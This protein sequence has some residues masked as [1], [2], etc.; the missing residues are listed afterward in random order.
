MNPTMQMQAVPAAANERRSNL[1][2]REI[3]SKL[4]EAVKAGLITRGEF[5]FLIRGRSQLMLEVATYKGMF[6]K[7]H[8]T[9]VLTR[10]GFEKK[11]SE[12]TVKYEQDI[13]DGKKVFYLSFAFD[14]DKFKSINDN[15]GHA[16]GDAVLRLFAGILKDVLKKDKDVIVRP[17]GDEFGVI[18]PIILAKDFTKEQVTDELERIKLLIKSRIEEKVSKYKLC[19][20]DK[21]EIVI[22]DTEKDTVPSGVQSFDF[23]ASC[24]ED[25][26]TGELVPDMPARIMSSFKIADDNI[27]YEKMTRKSEAAES[28]READ[29]D[30]RI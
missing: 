18:V 30:T 9:N 20:N 19:K 16:G 2:L 14:L 8:L 28:V 25:V 5:D 3:G 27:K 29:R 21:E 24:G 12:M 7:D 15:L 23:G 1:N 10:S 11:L 26:C 4:E 17:G 6:E 22:I 13:T